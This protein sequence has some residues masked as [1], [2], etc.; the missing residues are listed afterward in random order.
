M[1]ASLAVFSFLT[2]PPYAQRGQHRLHYIFPWPLIDTPTVFGITKMLDT[3]FGVCSSASVSAG[4]NEPAS[5]G[6]P[7]QAKSQLL[8]SLERSVN[9]WFAPGALKKF[10]VHEVYE[11]KAE[12]RTIAH[13]NLDD[14]SMRRM[15][16]PRQWMSP[17]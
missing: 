9:K 11:T 1:I 8:E 3:L 10:T 15:R 7:V 12:N 2:T 14:T 5:A 6:I 13:V 16:D 4:I 17:L